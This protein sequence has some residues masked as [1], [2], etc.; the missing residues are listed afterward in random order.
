MR[1][2]TPKVLSR[3]KAYRDFFFKEELVFPLV[4]C[5]ISQLQLII[6]VGKFNTYKEVK[7]EEKIL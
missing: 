4:P 3:K 6:M 7:R 2:C 5:V 1:L